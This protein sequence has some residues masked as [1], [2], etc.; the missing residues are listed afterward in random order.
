VKFIRTHIVFFILLFA[1]ALLRLFPLFEYQFTY[2]EL[3]G[4]D[5]TQFDSFSEL[6]Q[7]GVKID[8]HPALVQIFIF[9]IVKI[10]GFESWALKLPFLL[11]SLGSL[12]YAYA[13]GVNHFTK[14]AGLYA[15]VFFSFSLV[16]VF[17]APIARMY[18][19]GIFFSLAL[20]FYFLEIFHRNNH[21]SQ[22]YILLG[23]FALLSAY[24]HHMNALFAA[25]VMSCAFLFP[26]TINKVKYAVT[27]LCCLILYLPN[28]P[29]TLHQLSLGGIGTEQGGWLE[30]PDWWA[31]FE[32][33]KILFGTGYCW[34]FILLV[35][36][37]GWFLD[38]QK[39]LTKI[40][41]LLLVIFIVNYLVVYF[42][43]VFRAPVYQVS[44][45]LFAATAFII[46]VCSLLPHHNNLIFQITFTVMASLLLYQSY[47]KKDYLNQSVKT[48]FDYQFER[49]V[50]YK[51]LYGDENV[52]PVFFDADTLM[53]KIFFKKYDKKFNC[54]ISSD[55]S[56]SYG[57]RVF[58]RQVSSAGDR[59][60]SSIKLFS[61]L[62]QG[63][64]ENYIILSSSIP[65][66]QAIVKEHFPFLVEDTQTQAIHF[67]LYS[68]LPPARDSAIALLNYSDALNPGY[69]KYQF[70]AVKSEPGEK[71]INLYI[72]SSNVFPFAATASY[73]DVIT[74]E[75]QY[76][77]T[78]AK[79]K[80]RKFN[81][82]F[83]S[84]VV[85]NNAE[86]KEIS[87][88]ARV[89]SDFV[90]RPDSMTVLY[91]DAYIG[92]FHRK[93]FADKKLNCYLWNKN[94]ERAILTEF[95]IK[96]IDHWHN[97]WHFWD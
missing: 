62:V 42:Y 39:K 48:V 31:G 80:F 81:G 47:I 56:V 96:V 75:G 15:V 27:C 51:K 11:F 91:S 83:E 46:L 3:S 88:N 40:Q 41:W 7:K 54:L 78:C 70:S 30:K 76:V 60:V 73:D 12:V 20:L 93:P 33:I 9:Y 53:K 28:L 29:I 74:G 2:D 87:Y 49:T 5:R 4:L 43:S 24:N 95:N 8:A 32:L 34:I 1:T 19:S 66:Y 64:K 58:F 36:I 84:C 57:T 85:I 26:A 45:M 55:S 14:R 44:V 6:I 10:F 79:L 22:N 72:D 86:E 25:S 13:L 38:G 17:Y 61:E 92:N 50:H 69:F 67:Q 52:F 90:L 23:L 59:S 77:L 37:E 68:K 89:V 82:G 35:V 16:F 71:P 63:L 21:R 65:L 94:G 18:S 97:K